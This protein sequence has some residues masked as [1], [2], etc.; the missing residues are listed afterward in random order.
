MFSSSELLHYEILSW[1][2]EVFERGESCSR[3]LVPQGWLPT[4]LSL[5]PTATVCCCRATLS[6]QDGVSREVRSPLLPSQ[7][8][9]NSIQSLPARAALSRTQLWLQSHHLALI[10]FNYCTVIFFAWTGLMFLRSWCI[11]SLLLWL[12]LFSSALAWSLG[13]EV[14]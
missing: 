2:K 8:A 10:A 11:Q 14:S 6:V 5:L 4:S 12:C 1:R 13:V 9:L 7:P 3:L